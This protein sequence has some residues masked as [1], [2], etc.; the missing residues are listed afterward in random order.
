MA[1][2]KSGN[3]SL[4]IFNKFARDSQSAAVLGLLAH[5][6]VASWLTTFGRQWLKFYHDVTVYGAKGD[7]V[8][9]DT[10]AI[11]RPSKMIIAVAWNVA[12][13]SRKEPSSTSRP[14]IQGCEAFSGIALIDRDPYIPGGNRAN[15]YINQ[16]QSFRQIRNFV[17]D[18]TKIPVK[19]DDAGQPLSPT[20]IHW[21]VSQACTLQ[22]LVFKM[23]TET[24][25][26]TQ[27]GA[28]GWRAGSQQYTARNL[29]FRGCIQA[30]QITWDW[31]FNWEEINVDGGSVDFNISGKGGITQQGVGSVS[32][33]DCKFSNV[34][35]GILTDAATDAPPNM[36]IDNLV[37]SNVGAV[38]KTSED[39]VLIPA[40]GHGRAS[41]YVGGVPSR[42]ASLLSGGSF[43]SRSRPQYETLGT[44][45]FLVATA[46][47]IKKDGTGD[48]TAAIDSFLQSAVSQ[49]E[50]AYFP[51][52]VYQVQ[53]T[54]KVP[55]GS[56]IQGSSWSQIMATGSYFGDIKNPKVM[57]KAGEPGDSGV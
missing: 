55:L 27:G 38:V 50:M 2:L 20:G 8:H 35:T 41:T 31:G 9:D 5:F 15:W 16:N 56:R 33:I 34:P 11:M 14:I 21:Q 10:E 47:G 39:E 49:G 53:S 6:S 44:G 19:T 42:P 37:T 22:D 28:I 57:V 30:V 32:V 46:Q 36:V 48:Q 52:G 7:G 51:A 43:F 17:F 12:I 29:K 26:G 23:P 4:L 3:M 40:A 54:M 18:L 24:G 25:N 45:D 1:N 13:P